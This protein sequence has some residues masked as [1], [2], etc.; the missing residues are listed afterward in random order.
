MDGQT[1]GIQL[2]RALS[3]RG[4]LRDRQRQRAA[5]S[6]SLSFGRHFGPP[7][8]TARQ[9]AVMLL[10]ETTEE[11]EW[12]EW[13]IPLTVRPHH[14]PS[15]PGQISL[16]G[17]RVE[18][19]ESLQRA[20]E[21]ELEEELGIAAFPGNV[22]GS[23]QELYV[24]NSDYYVT[25]FV[26]HCSKL[27]SCIPCPREVERVIHLPLRMLLA[28]DPQRE[29]SFSRGLAEWRAPVIEIGDDQ[30]WGATAIILGELGAVLKHLAGRV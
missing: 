23:L 28:K 3:D 30:I 6:P 20:A 10:V 24:Y 18:T 14:L 9:A 5:F 15:H 27:P 12:P 17:G 1:F 7:L 21:R 26:S 4:L 11:V 29:V 22:I 8:P 25:P 2:E 13:T 16:P 19:G